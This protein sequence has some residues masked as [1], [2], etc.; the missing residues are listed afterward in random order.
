MCF[1]SLQHWQLQ[2]STVSLKVQS[3]SH[4]TTDICPDKP[5][6]DLN[7]T[8]LLIAVVML[9]SL[10]VVICLVRRKSS[11]RSC[12]SFQNIKSRVL[13]KSKDAATVA[14]IGKGRDRMSVEL[15]QTCIE[16]NKMLAQLAQVTGYKNEIFEPCDLC[17]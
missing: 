11:K 9:L 1:L 2:D 15:C 4:P 8:S 16:S 14:Y 17:R 3:G 10:C 13:L 5:F 12:I 6:F 7:F